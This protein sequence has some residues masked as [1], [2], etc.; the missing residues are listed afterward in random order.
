MPELPEVEV[1]RLG[2]SPFVVGKTIVDIQTPHPRTTRDIGSVEDFHNKIL[3]ARIESSSRIGKYMI[4]WLCG[5][6]HKISALIIHL[7]MSGRLYKSLEEPDQL[8][9]TKHLNFI[10]KFSDNS[11]LIFFDPRTFGK[12]FLDTS[13]RRPIPSYLEK[14]GPDALNSL[15]PMLKI[16]TYAKNSSRAIKHL[17]LDQ[18]LLAGVG[19]IYGDE[20]LNRCGIAPNRP[21]NL[22]SENELEMISDVMPK[23]LRRAVM[24]RGSSLVDQG[25]R[26]IEG[27][28]GEFQKFHRVYGRGG[29]PCLSC[30]EEILRVSIA[31]R[32]S[33]YCPDC[34]V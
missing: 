24:L 9:P 28:L 7:G 29:K 2:L 33:F 15:D 31:S 3:G 30:G 25:Y 16:V 17:M 14:L 6:N 21:A 34:Q 12:V 8:I 4:L 27:N 13:G 20:I 19:N 11:K 23:L 22:V 1:L 32:S 26:D 18:N 5:Q 10:V